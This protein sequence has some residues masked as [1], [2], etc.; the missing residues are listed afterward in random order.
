MR[1]LKASPISASKFLGTGVCSWALAAGIV[2]AGSLPGTALAQA[3]VTD[4][5]SAKSNDLEAQ[6]IIVTGTLWRSM[7]LCYCATSETSCLWPKPPSALP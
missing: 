1:L 3:A 6:E 7:A 2:A 5:Q 4:E